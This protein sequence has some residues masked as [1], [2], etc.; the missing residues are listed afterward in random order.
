MELDDEIHAID[1]RLFSEFSRAEKVMALLQHRPLCFKF[2]RPM[3]KDTYFDST[4]GR[5]DEDKMGLG[6]KGTKV[7][8]LD[9]GWDWGLRRRR[10]G[11]KATKVRLGLNRRRQDFEA[12]RVRFGFKTNE[13][14]G[15]RIQ[16][17]LDMSGPPVL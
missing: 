11:L 4:L 10:L 13:A 15:T 8:I 14:E 6:F 5:T 2:K 3:I 12:T 17:R 7:K 16:F 1:G 9:T